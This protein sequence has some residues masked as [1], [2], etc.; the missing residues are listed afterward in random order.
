VASINHNIL[1]KILADNINGPFA[2]RGD[3]SHARAAVSANSNDAA[4]QIE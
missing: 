1:S 3:M 2:G 4:A